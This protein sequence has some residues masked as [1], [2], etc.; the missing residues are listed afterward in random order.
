MAK[1][2]LNR[3]VFDKKKFEQSVDTEFSQL[4]TKPEQK[5]FDLN[6]ATL[7]D[8]FTL[9]TNLFYEIPKEGELNSHS[10]LIKE[11]SE[12]INFEQINE[13]IQALLEEITSLRTELLEKEQTA[14]DLEQKLAQ[15]EVNI[16]ALQ[17]I[18]LSTGTTG[19]G[20]Y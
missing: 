17:S 19:G 4:V 11:S 18:G 7:D 1:V 20:G 2:N 14:L 12:Y 3:T 16:S 8:F 13:D 9:Y 15:A 6:L 10:Y 5:F